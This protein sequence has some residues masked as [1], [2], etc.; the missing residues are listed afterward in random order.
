MVVERGMGVSLVKMGLVVKPAVKGVQ[1]W[2]VLRG[3]K[4]QLRNMTMYK[5]WAARTDVQR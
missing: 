4:V 5:P 2:G 3:C 1:V